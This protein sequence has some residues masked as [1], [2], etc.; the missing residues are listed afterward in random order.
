MSKLLRGFLDSET[1]RRPNMA[2]GNGRIRKLLETR[3]AEALRIDLGLLS[4]RV[5]C[6]SKLEKTDGV[7][8]LYAACETARGA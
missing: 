3:I 1:P 5:L 2:A 6:F 4:I 8:P 7:T